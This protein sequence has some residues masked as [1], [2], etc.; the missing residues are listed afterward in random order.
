MRGEL[1]F[2]RNDLGTCAQRS[3]VMSTLLLLFQ[4]CYNKY[5]VVNKIVIVWDSK[6]IIRIVN[7]L[8]ICN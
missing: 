5:V 2:D 8:F 3:N 6:A 4:L 1:H 7:R